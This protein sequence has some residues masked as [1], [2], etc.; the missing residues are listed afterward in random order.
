MKFLEKSI[1]QYNKQGDDTN[2]L[3]LTHNFTL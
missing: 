3:F 1:A 2:T